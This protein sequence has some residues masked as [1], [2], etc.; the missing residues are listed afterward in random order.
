MTFLRFRCW[1]TVDTPECHCSPYP[2]SWPPES[3]FP[4]R[5]LPVS[6]QN[7][8]RFSLRMLRNPDTSLGPA[9]PAPWESETVIYVTPGISPNLTELHLRNYTGWV[10]TAA[11]TPHGR[12]T[13]AVRHRRSST[14]HPTESS[15]RHPVE[16]VVPGTPW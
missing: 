7:V 1:Y 13:R 10:H 16:R 2:H 9:F 6:L 12:G 3:H 14:R 15:T 8:T 5:M 4:L 11:S